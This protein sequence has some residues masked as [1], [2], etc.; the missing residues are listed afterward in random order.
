MAI[1]KQGVLSLGVLV[2]ALLCA[3]AFV[4]QANMAL[5]GIGLGPVLD[6]IGLSVAEPKE[7]APARGGQRGGGEPP[8]VVARA[9]GE[10]RIADKVVAIGDGQAIRAVTVVAETPGRVTEVLVQSGQ[11]VQEGGVLLRLDR[12]AETIAVERAQLVLDDA[13]SALERLQQLQGSGA[14]TAV[15]LREAELSLRQAE[16]ELRQVEFDLSLREIPAPVS[17]WIGILNAEVGAQITTA[18]EIAEIDDRSVLLVDFRL[19]ERMV[20]RIAPGDPVMAEALAGGFEEVAGTISAIDNRVD[21]ASRTLRVQARLD[22]ADDRLRAG[23]SFAI[24]IDL[25]GE[26]AA[27]VD[28]L[29]VQWNRDGAYVWVV[30]DEMAQRLPIR[31]LQRAENAV[32]VAAEFAP[33]DLVIVEGVQSVRPGA[34]VRVQG[35]TAAA[36]TSGAADSP[37]KL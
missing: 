27:S 2:V 36:E 24:T 13:R 22:N 26:P 10:G 28:P 3:A 35:E 9:P 21:P 25:P 6:G 11:Q 29:A 1:W 37:A 30:R 7:G 20:G 19:P 17:G 14:S 33:G 18:T 16:L 34:P 23:M 32:L 12:E 8:L 5:R 31:I 4:P 15:Q